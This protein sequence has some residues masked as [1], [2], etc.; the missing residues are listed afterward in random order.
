MR[1]DPSLFTYW[2][3]VPV[4]FKDIDLGGHAHHSHALV[5]FEEARAA[6]WRDVVGRDSLD[7][8]EFILAE[9]RVRYHERILYPHQLRV[10]VRVSLLGK[11]HFKMEYLVLAEDG[12]ELVSGDTT[13]VMFD[14]GAG[15]TKGVP[16]QVREAVTA[17]EGPGLQEKPLG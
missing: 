13:M 12:R 17:H 15:R 5:Y 14:Y 16:A 9:A 11:K 6:Y 1:P 2:Q 3:T 10:G 4:R 8:V 7:E